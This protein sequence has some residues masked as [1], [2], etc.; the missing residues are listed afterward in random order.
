MT[1]ALATLEKQRNDILTEVRNISAKAEEAGRGFTDDED[2]TVTERLAKAGELNEQITSLKGVIK[3]NAQIA[4]LMGKADADALNSEVLKNARVGLGG[5]AASIGRLFTDSDQYQA[6]MKAHNGRIADTAKNIRFD[7]PVQVG[8]FKDLL[9]GSNRTTGAGT[10]LTPDDLGVVEYR[11]PYVGGIRDLV[12][13]G[14]TG[15]DKVEYAQV[16]PD[17]AEPGGTQSNAR[18]VYEATTENPVG[19]DPDGAGPGGPVTARQAGV[20]PK[21]KMTFKKVSADVITVAH[22]MPA[23]KRSLSDVRQLR[24]LIDNFLRSGVAREFE[25]LMLTG[26]KDAPADPNYEEFDGLLN[27]TGVQSQPWAGNVIATAR[28]MIT[29]VRDKG[30]QLTAF[31]VSPAVNEA[32]D[33]LQDRDGR[34]LGNGPF[35][36][37]PQTLWGRPRVEVP[38]LAD[39]KIIGGEW[40]TLC[41]WDREET[42]LTATDAH[43]DFFVRNLVAVLAEARA[44]FGALNPQLMCVG[45]VTDADA[46]VYPAA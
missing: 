16:I 43:E 19:S 1:L 11:A 31:A 10:L 40:S 35:S 24:T 8:G 46:P 14:S 6:L 18:G 36:Q 2:A 21:S 44:A 17:G 25:R 45:E 32:I 4:E 15:T 30:G 33:L 23:T 29:K 39:D 42:T 38:D 22:W 41:L 37:G 5:K 12:T 28:K 20:K 9:T 34:F 7:A 3:T 26:D 13:I 27:I